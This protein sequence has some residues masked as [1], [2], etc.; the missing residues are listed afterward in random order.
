MLIK[1]LA[2]DFDD[3]ATSESNIAYHI[4]CPHIGIREDEHHPC[5]DATAPP[6]KWDQLKICGTCIMEWL[7]EEVAQ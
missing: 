2:D 7:N 1:S 3:P 4:A 6:W 5:D